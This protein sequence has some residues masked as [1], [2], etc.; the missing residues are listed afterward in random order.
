MRHKTI[1][2]IK[3]VPNIL[4]PLIPHFKRSFPYVDR[5]LFIRSISLIM[6]N[7]IFIHYAK[8]CYFPFCESFSFVFC[9]S[10]LSYILW[11]NIKAFCPKIIYIIISSTTI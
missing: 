3:P 7:I 8:Y 10:T 4:E 11:Y 1:C 6:Y 5:I 9:Q 2:Y